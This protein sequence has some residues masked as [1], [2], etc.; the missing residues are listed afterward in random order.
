MQLMFS[1]FEE[2]FLNRCGYSFS[3]SFSKTTS[4]I[5]LAEGFNLI[6]NPDLFLNAGSFPERIHVAE[7]LA[8][9]FAFF[10]LDSNHFNSS[11]VFFKD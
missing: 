11:S 3:A 10:A 1:P 2:C 9:F 6:S 5:I 4:G 8:C 7:D